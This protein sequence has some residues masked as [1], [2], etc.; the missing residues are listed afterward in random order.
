M[1]DDIPCGAS[2]KLK[3]WVEET[4]PAPS[5]QGPQEEQIEEE[6]EEEAGAEVMNN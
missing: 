4:P 6:E 5:E 2:V 3:P 1:V